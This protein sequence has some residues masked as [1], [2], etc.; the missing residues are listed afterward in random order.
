MLQLCGEQA[1]MLLAPAS[2]GACLGPVVAP[3]PVLVASNI[4]SLWTLGAKDGLW[5]SLRE[6]NIIIH[7]A[8]MTFSFYISGGM[9]ASQVEKLDP[10]GWSSTLKPVLKSTCESTL[11]AA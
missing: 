6:A 10:R 7:T 11:G 9:A 4:W 5:D 8:I 1:T 2:H 3:Y